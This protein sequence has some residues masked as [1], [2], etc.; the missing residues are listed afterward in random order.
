MRFARHGQIL[1]AAQESADSAARDRDEVP[2]NSPPRSGDDEP[3]ANGGSDPATWDTWTDR[4]AFWPTPQPTRRP[5]RKPRGVGRRALL[6]LVGAS[7]SGLILGRGRAGA[8]VVAGRVLRSS[9]C[10]PRPLALAY[11]SLL[12]ARWSRV[13][14]ELDPRRH[15]PFGSPACEAHERRLVEA[16]KQ[17][18][19]AERSL[20]ELIART[21]GV[22]PTARTAEAIM[23]ITLYRPIAATV[24][25]GWVYQ[26]VAVLDGSKVVVRPV[27]ID[28]G[29]TA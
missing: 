9:P 15:E 17:E 25:N 5:D 26:A 1:Q 2:V 7:A 20:V 27:V 3:G 22:E 10:T 13:D 24:E 19:A 23:D 21:A 16:T 29:A 18:S 28:L 12:E 6:G 14:A 8:E 11:S 4:I